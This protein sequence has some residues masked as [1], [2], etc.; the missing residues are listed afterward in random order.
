MTERTR[1]NLR[2]FGALTIVIVIGLL[3]V[4]FMWGVTAS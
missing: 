4:L 1:Q 3:Q 2:L